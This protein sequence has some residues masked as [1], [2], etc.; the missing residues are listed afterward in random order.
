MEEGGDPI[1]WNQEILIPA[2][3]PLL[4]KRIVLKVMDEDMTGDEV[5]G[6]ILLDKKDI[7]DGKYKGKYVWKNIYGSPMNMKNSK[8]K[9]EMNENPEIA[10]NWKGRV[11]LKIDCQKTEKPVAKVKYIVQEEVAKAAIHTKPKDYKILAEIGQGIALPAEKKYQVRMIIGGH[12]IET[13][14][15]KTFQ[16]KNYN[17]YNQRFE[18]V[19]EKPY[20]DIMD[21]GNV[22]IQLIDDKGRPVC[23][24][25]ERINEFAKADA[26][27]KWVSLKPDLC[28]NQVKDINLAGMLSF[29]LSVVEGRD[30]DIPDLEAKERK[31][32]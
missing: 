16:K 4:T 17:R 8:A 20:V 31:R 27:Y 9:R 18:E 13:D 14:K 2:Q 21:F 24:Y 28:V 12:I 15:S 32:K 23:Y 29:K 26:D 30:T 25:K 22:I 19:I 5:V 11:L 10:S 6:S 1:R 3:Y 7:L